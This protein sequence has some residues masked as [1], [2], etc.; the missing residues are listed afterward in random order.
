MR[1]EYIDGFPLGI[2][3]LAPG[4]FPSVCTTC[5]AMDSAKIFVKRQLDSFLSR[6]GV[7][8]GLKRFL[9][10]ASRLVSDGEGIRGGK[11]GSLLLMQRRSGD[12][13]RK[14]RKFCIDAA[15]QWRPEAEKEE[16]L[17]WTR[18]THRARGDF[19]RRLCFGVR[20]FHRKMQEMQRGPGNE[21]NSL[22]RN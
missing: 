11:G 8:A 14:R 7:G 12:Q 4:S 18:E 20:D 17:Y 21:R 2:H 19:Q 13:R 1:T 6:E 22:T 3:T 15:T 16:V 10:D 5:N 9:L